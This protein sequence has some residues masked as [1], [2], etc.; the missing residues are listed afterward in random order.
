MKHGLILP[1]C[2][3]GPEFLQ[4]FRPFT[5]FVISTYGSMHILESNT[6]D[7]LASLHI[8]VCC[9]ESYVSEW[10]IALNDPFKRFLLIGF[11]DISQWSTANGTAPF[12]SLCSACERGLKFKN[13]YPH[14][15]NLY[16]QTFNIKN[17]VCSLALSKRE[18]KL[19]SDQR[20]LKKLDF[21]VPEKLS[22]K[23]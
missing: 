20:H 1:S 10:F 8:L 6:C 3:G 19:K 14:S 16:A 11:G 13:I 5:H 22:T 4:P 21:E 15:L 17:F 7:H 18:V 23:S 12:H 2:S 9:H